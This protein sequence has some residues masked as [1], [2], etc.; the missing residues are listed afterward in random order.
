MKATASELFIDEQVIKK[1]VGTLLLQLEQRRAQQIDAATAPEK[2]VELSAAEKRAAMKLLRSPNLT[3]RI[4][5]D[6]QTCGL[7]GEDTNKLVC[8]LLRAELRSHFWP[9]FECMDLRGDFG[10]LAELL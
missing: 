8:Y 3:D 10:G 1:D 4:L 9:N 7:V 6:F 5:E 2:P